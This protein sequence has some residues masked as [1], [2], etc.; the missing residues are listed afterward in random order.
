MA[1]TMENYDTVCFRQRWI[2]PCWIAAIGWNR[3]VVTNY[4]ILRDP[5]GGCH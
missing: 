3:Y 4:K 5:E 1:V 2:Q